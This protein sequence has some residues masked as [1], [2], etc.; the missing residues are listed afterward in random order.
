MK[1]AGRRLSLLF[2]AVSLTGVF[3]FGIALLHT[4]SP[5][6]AQTITSAPDGTGTIVTPDGNRFDIHGGTRSRDGANLFH[7]FNEFGINSSQVANFLANPQIHNILGRVV[8]GEASVINGLIQVTGG[9][10]N[11]FLM[12]PAGIMFGANA[13]LNVPAAFTATTANGIGFNSGWFSAS[14]SNNYAALVGKPNAFAFTMSQPGAITSSG[15]L[16]VGV[17][18]SPLVST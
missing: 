16:A 8:G 10:A 15:N 9:N 14:G 5:A 12:N 11:L 3:P 6:L 1:F 2:S 7:S 17:G 4:T 13:T 18:Q